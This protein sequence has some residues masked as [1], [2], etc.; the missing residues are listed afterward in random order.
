MDARRRNI[1]VCFRSVTQRLNFR[2]A[3]IPIKIVVICF[4]FRVYRI[5]FISEIK[6]ERRGAICKKKKAAG[7]DETE[8]RIE[9][10]RSHD[11][12]DDDLHECRDMR[13]PREHSHISFYFISRRVNGGG[14]SQNRKC[15]I[16][17]CRD[18]RITCARARVTTSCA[19]PSVIINSYR[20]RRGTNI[21]NSRKHSRSPHMSIYFSHI[22][23]QIN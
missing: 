11:D 6:W 14:S 20:E 2:H 7:R 21:R 9:Y 10:A 4:M 1:R 17:G 3:S 16:V 15:S 18:T 22:D 19:N 8:A 23:A 12:D 13:E 5:F